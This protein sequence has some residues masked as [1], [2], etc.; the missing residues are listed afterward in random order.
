MNREP[1]DW[2]RLVANVALDP[3]PEPTPAPPD[4]AARVVAV[5]HTLRRDEQVRRWARW[6]LRGA[7]VA[8]AGCG[9]M[10]AIHHQP[11]PPILLSPPTDP[12]LTPH[13]PA[14]APE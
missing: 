13:F 7:L 9:I 1:L 6:S 5:W 8:A 10:L 2:N 11:E 12:L 3:T 14:Q 4:L